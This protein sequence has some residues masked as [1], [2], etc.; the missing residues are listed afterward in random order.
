M[1]AVASHSA[2][3]SVTIPDAIEALVIPL[4]NLSQEICDDNRFE[5]LPDSNDETLPKQTLSTQ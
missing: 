3:G 1:R 5:E 4:P 2:Q